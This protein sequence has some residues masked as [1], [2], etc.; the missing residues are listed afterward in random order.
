M[1]RR[2]HGRESNMSEINTLQ[3]SPVKLILQAPNAVQWYGMKR[4]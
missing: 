3:P 1:A 2:L 4:M